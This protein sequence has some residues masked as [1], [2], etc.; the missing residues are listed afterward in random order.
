M[1]EII[2]DQTN[3]S[4]ARALDVLRVTHLDGNTYYDGEDY[5]NDM[6]AWQKVIPKLTKSQKLLFVDALQ[7]ITNC[8][9]ADQFRK[10]NIFD[11]IFSKPNQWAEA[12][13]LSME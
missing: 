6:N 8:R 11:F 1:S 2:G 13:L 5:V 4:I 3:I 7:E 10:L 9:C 12:Y